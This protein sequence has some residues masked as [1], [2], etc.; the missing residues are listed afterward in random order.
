[1]S[2]Q[3]ALVARG[4]THNDEL[5]KENREGH[6]L[7]WKISVKTMCVCWFTEHLVFSDTIV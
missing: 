6:Q 7:A 5:K 3:F 2:I 4:C 1:M